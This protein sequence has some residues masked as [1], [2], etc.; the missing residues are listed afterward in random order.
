MPSLQ[1][2][3]AWTVALQEAGGALVY[4]YNPS[5]WE[6]KI[7]EGTLDILGLANTT[8]ADLALLSQSFCL[9]KTI[10]LHSYN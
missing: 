3:L 2:P 7:S 6:M 10:K 8:L 5:T 9:A 4:V 1:A